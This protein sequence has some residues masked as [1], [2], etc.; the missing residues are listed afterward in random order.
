MERAARTRRFAV[1]AIGAIGAI[2][3]L[4]GALVPTTA[5]AATLIGLLPSPASEAL[6]LSVDCANDGSGEP[7]SMT[8]QI[9][10]LGPAL[11]PVVSLQARRN[12]AAKSTT[13]GIDADGTASPVVILNEGAGRYDLYV[14]K[15][16]AG[17]E[18]FEV[19][20]QCWTGPNGTGSATGTTLRSA[21]GEPVP[22]L[23]PPAGIGLLG[24]SLALA[25]AELRARPRSTRPLDRSDSRSALLLLALMVGGLAWLAPAVAGAHSQPGSLG[26]PASA[27][28]YYEIACFDDGHGQPGSL[29]LQIRDASPGAAPFVSVQGHHGLTVRSVSDDLL[30]DI[31]PSPRI[32]LNGG[33]V[34]Y[35]VLVDKS[36]AGGKFYD[37]TYHCWTG[38]DGTGV[39]T[40]TSLIIR[41]SE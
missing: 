6:L 24:L 4:L 25:M 36:G 10:D 26:T 23:L 11:A 35:F 38:P 15:N 37:L 19:V 12:F 40:G 18:A 3:S 2:G 17:E 5:R 16:G 34:S 7:A 33:A 1:L 39:H 31:L 13:D 28:D 27:T 41:Q 29:E 20:A 9:R 21:Q 14:D 8:V 22:T 30:A 32:F